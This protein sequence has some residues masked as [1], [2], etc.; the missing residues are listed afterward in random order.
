MPP[1]SISRT[2]FNL[3]VSYKAG[4]VWRGRE[5]APGVQPGSSQRLGGDAGDR[6]RSPHG[7]SPGTQLVAACPA[8]LTGSRN[9]AE[10]RVT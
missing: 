4:K 1:F 9:S 3:F 10:K 8:T 7:R 6:P 5:E 2:L